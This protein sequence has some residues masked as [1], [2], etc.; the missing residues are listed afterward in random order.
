MI[1]QF[2]MAYGIEQD[3]IRA[4]LP[5]GYESLRPVLRINA[6]I[7]DEERVYLEFNTPVA[8]DGKRGWLNIARW[9]SPEV[10]FRRE[11]GVVI[12][13][14]PFL[15]LAYKGV[16]ITGGCP[17]EKDN[18]G[19]FYLGKSPE[20]C[21]PEQ[22]TAHKEF[23]DCE[24]AWRFHG[25]DASGVSIGKTLPAFPEEARQN[26]PRKPLTAANAAAIPCRQVLGA[27]IVRFERQTKTAEI[28][29]DISLRNPTEGT[30]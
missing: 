2:V 12:L 29:E 19:C 28:T 15:Q 10:A 20:F 22:I 30:I 4:L 26:Y 24:F 14:A 13:N 5:E 25:D 18:D 7:R 6:E 23:C 1:E 17:A 11:N 3:R 9:Q 21:P 8:H 27:Y 16:G